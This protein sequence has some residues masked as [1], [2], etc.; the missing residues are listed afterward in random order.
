MSRTIFVPLD[1]SRFSEF[2]LSRA[3]TLAGGDGGRIHLATVVAPLPTEPGTEGE[4]SPVPAAD[5]TKSLEAGQTYLEEVSQ[6]VRL[7]ADG[8]EVTSEALPPGNIVGSLRRAIQDVDPDLLVMTTHGRGVLERVW[9]GSVADGLI[10][11][12]QRPILLVRPPEEAEVGEERPDPKPAVP[13]QRILVPLDGSRASTEILEPVGELAKDSGA[14]VVLF[15]VVPS[16]SAGAYP[17]MTLPAREESTPTVVVKSAEEEMESLAE[18][19]RAKGVKVEVEVRILN[20]PAV[21]ILQRSEKADVDLVA[22]TTRGRG[23]VARLVLGSVADKV[24][25]AT[26]LPLLVH[27]SDEEA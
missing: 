7:R 13:F 22:M 15:R 27:R 4:S 2:A 24:I 5:R 16:L 20:H 21:A 3:L 18:A 26:D 11:R 12:V 14:S 8:A 25:R 19:L 1:G 17:Y 23:G 6:R 9:L 10:R